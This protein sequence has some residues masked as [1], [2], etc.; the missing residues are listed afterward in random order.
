[1]IGEAGALLEPM[2]LRYN[3]SETDAH[4][5]LRMHGVLD[6]SQTRRITLEPSGTISVIKA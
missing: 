3:I 2:M 6:A 1:V 4:E 5:A